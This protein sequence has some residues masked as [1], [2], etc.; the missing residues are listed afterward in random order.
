MAP[1][2]LLQPLE[3]PNKVWEEVSMDFIDGLPRSEGFTVILVVV[4]RLSK[5]AH[6][7]LLRHPYTAVSVAA[8]FI[9]EVVR[10]HG[11]PASIVSDRDRVFLSQFWK[12]LFRM[13]GTILKRSTAY[14]PQTDGQTEVVNRSLETYLR[15][16]ASETPRKWAK[17]LPW[18]EYWYNTSYHS[19]SQ[20]TPFKVLYGRDPPHLVHYEKGNTAI[21]SV[22]QY[23]EERD[24][25]L[26]ELKKHLGRAQQIMKKRADTH[27]RDIQFEVGE[28]VFLKLRP[29]RQ[30]S[31]ANRRNEKLAPRYF[32]PYEVTGRVGA[33]AYRLKLPQY[34][35][36]HPVFHVSQL[37]R[38]LGEHVASPELPASLTEELE[39]VMEPMELEGVRVNKIGTKEVLIKWKDLPD[40]EATWEPYEMVKQQFPDFHLEDKVNLWEGSNVTSG[41]VPS[42]PF[43]PE[44]FLEEDS[45]VEA[46]GNNFRFIPF[47]VG[48]HSCPG[49]ILALPILGITLGRLV[50]NFELLPPPGMEK[51]DTSEKGGQ[52]SLHILK[53][54][55]VLQQNSEI[56]QSS[57]DIVE[58]MEKCKESAGA[59]SKVLEEEKDRYQK[60]AMAV[61]QMLG[62]TDIP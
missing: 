13:Q 60:A 36:I 51:L 10:L 33:V 56:E 16:F 8:A 50:Q 6:F 22:E 26:E 1:G 19:A 29:Y 53:H 4:D 49:I 44:H 46:N 37:R 48:R 7:I 39:V 5:Y 35:T 52:F 9:R 23:L 30:R 47:G 40:Y 32:G 57:G 59:K 25:V 45:K 20:M 61:L 27:R 43:R 38:A 2:G 54:Y 41:P 58:E 24:Q 15:C 31:V 12:E 14:H 17:W 11:F 34:A 3:L 42:G 18:A 62:G 55:T 28:K 21:F